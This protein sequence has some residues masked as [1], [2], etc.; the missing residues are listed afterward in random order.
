MS[1]SYSSKASS[2]IEAAADGIMLVDENHIIES[3]NPAF[4]NITGISRKALIGEDCRSA[5][6]NIST[7]GGHVCDVMCPFSQPMVRDPHHSEVSIRT[8]GGDVRWVGVTTAPMFASSGQLVGVVHTLRDTSER[9]Q[10]GA[11][12]D[13]FISLVSHEFRSPVTVIL[14]MA[15]TLLRKE[16]AL[17]AV[18]TSGLR[19][20]VCQAWRLNR[21]IDNLLVIKRCR[22]GSLELASELVQVEKIC[23]KVVKDTQAQDHKCSLDMD[24]PDAFPVA[25]GDARRLEIVLRN[26]LDNAVKYSP[27][28]GKIRI[29]GRYEDPSIVVGVEDQ[30]I[31]VP[32][33]HLESIFQGFQRL[34]DPRVQAKPGAGL[35]LAACHLIVKAHGGRLWVK[36]TPGRGSLFAFTLPCS[37]R[38]QA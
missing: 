16:M 33:E 22:D 17:P 4:E 29:W 11:L 20:I 27:D 37:D 38:V 36:S 23:A 32:A 28:G 26:L 1:E 15:S 24:F 6:Q 35:G 9:R 5:L 8:A 10:C 3:A 21:L 18:A 7:E 2:A 14:G 25:V 31:G 12:G 13:D 19:D 34:D 30:G